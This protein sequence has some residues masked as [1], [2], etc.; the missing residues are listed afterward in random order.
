[1]NGGR[2]FYGPP[3]GG[4]F[5]AGGNGAD[6]LAGI[7]SLPT[8][9]LSN[10]PGV[11]GRLWLAYVTAARSGPVSKLMVAAGDTAADTATLGR[12]A[13]FTADPDGTVDLVARTASD[14][15]IGAGTYAPYERPMAT[16]GGF[17]ASYQI[18]AGARYAIGW[19]QLADTPMSVQGAYVLDPATE[20]VRC[21]V[22]DGQTDILTSYDAGDLSAHYQVPYLRAR[23]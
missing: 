2:T 13:L 20:P 4:P 17:P 8:V 16:A 6:A 11:S 15:A 18:T 23:A 19:L 3:A 7:E 12:I 1:V 9:G 10:F 5:V 21:R 22:I 14:P